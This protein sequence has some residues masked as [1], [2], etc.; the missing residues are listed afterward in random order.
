[1]FKLKRVEHFLIISHI[2]EQRTHPSLERLPY[3]VSIAHVSKY[4]E[5]D[6]AGL[7]PVHSSLRDAEGWREEGWTDAA[8]EIGR[9]EGRREQIEHRWSDFVQTHADSN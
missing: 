5:N 8:R 2:L 4:P 7:E 3:Q 1:M 9:K 6:N